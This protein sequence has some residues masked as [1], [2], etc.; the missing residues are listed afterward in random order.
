MLRREEKDCNS[1]LLSGG[2]Y[3]GVGMVLGQTPKLVD[4]I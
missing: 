3:G 4:K 2:G 1:A